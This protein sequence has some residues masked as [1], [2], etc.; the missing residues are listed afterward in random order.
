MADEI[1]VSVSLSTLK[2]NFSYS[3]SIFDNADQTTARGSGAV[4]AV[5]TTEEQV[6]VSSDVATAG[7]AVFRNLNTTGSIEIGLFISATFYPLIK[8]KSGEPALLR[9]GT[10]TF[11]AK[12]SVASDLEYF[13]LAD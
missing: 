7:W 6:V 5:G 4:Q 11:Y 2:G 1:T 8:L 10:N 3:R 9:L 12:A 13:I